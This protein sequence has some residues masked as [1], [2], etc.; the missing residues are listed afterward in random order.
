MKAIAL[1]SGGLDSILAVR[2]IQRQGVTV[3]PLK[4]KIP[5]LHSN[6]EKTC[7]NPEAGLRTVDISDDFLKM[8][9]NPEHGY[10]ANMNPCIDC[11]ILMLR[12]AKELMPQF[13]AQFIVTG[14]VLGQ[15][16]MSQNKKALYAIAEKA[17]LE[18]LVVRPL[19][20]RLLKETIPEKKGWINRQNLL[21]FN[22]RSR[23]PQME[24]AK[25]FGIKDYAQPAGGCLLTDPEFTKRLKDLITHKD[26]NMKNVGLLKIGRHFRLTS[27]TKLVV[28]RNEGENERLVKFTQDEDYLFLPNEE[29][30][31]P[32]ALGRGIFN[33][34][35]IKL[36]CSIT[37]SY[38]DLNGANNA[39][40]VYKKIPDE[41]EK[42]LDVSAIK[43]KG[44]QDFRI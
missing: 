13:G 33:E 4:F 29:L 5:F 8:L 34:E 32:T 26:L 30:A 2:L 11:K 1:I 25:A 24:L 6:K 35:L 41:E 20:A 43:E 17:E 18:G 37:C 7:H 42:M 14:E 27:K 40:I 12:K 38:C 21:D 31:G 15:R 44:L 39:R 36:S 16:P 28:G 10:G 22:G 3:V 23:R 9:K 19:C